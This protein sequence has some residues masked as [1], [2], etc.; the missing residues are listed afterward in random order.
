MSHKY[1][2]IN[3]RRVH[4][5]LYIYIYTL[6]RKMFLKRYENFLQFSY[7]YCCGSAQITTAM[8]QHTNPNT[9]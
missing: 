6:R 3:Y 2:C 4:T 1:R 5:T 9:R 8:T 7:Y